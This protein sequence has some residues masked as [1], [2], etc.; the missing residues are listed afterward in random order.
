MQHNW[1]GFPGGYCLNCGN[2][3][4]VEDLL[5]CRDCVVDPADEYGVRIL[6]YCPLHEAWLAALE[7]GCP[8]EPGLVREVNR[9]IAEQA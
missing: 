5:C 7:S 8:P 2:E 4:A 1:S 6:T 3:S 9:L